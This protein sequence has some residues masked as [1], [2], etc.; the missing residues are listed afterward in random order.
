M[1]LCERLVSS[2]VW[3]VRVVLGLIDLV[4]LLLRVKAVGRR[5]ARRSEQPFSVVAEWKRSVRR[6]GEKPFL[7]VCAS[8]D[9]VIRE[10]SYAATDELAEEFAQWLG[11]ST[12][13][14]RGETVGV[15]MGTSAEFVVILLGL[16]KAGCRAA[17]VN[18]AL[19]GEPL[20]HAL[21]SALGDRKPRLIV[22]DAE[23]A[24]S[25][26]LSG[27]RARVV[28][29]NS[30][31]G[32]KLRLWHKQRRLNKDDDDLLN[33]DLD[34]LDDDD[35]KRN[36]SRWRFSLLR[37]HWRFRVPPAGTLRRVA[38]KD[39]KHYRR[40]DLEEAAAATGSP[41]ESSVDRKDEDIF[42]YIYTSGTTGLPKAARITHARA[43]S[44]G[45]CFRTTCRLRDSDRV[46][47]ALPLYHATAGLMGLFGV[48]GAGASLLLRRK[49]STSA[50][51]EDLL[52]KRAT[53][54]LYVGEMARYLASSNSSS[55]ETTL[56]PPT[57]KAPLRKKNLRFAFGNGMPVD[58]WEAFRLCLGVERVVEFYGS[59]EGNV[60][61]FNNVGV[62]G[63]CGLVPRPFLWL[64]PIFVARV[65]EEDDGSC[66]LL[67]DG[68][69]GLCVQCR[70]NEAGELLG[71][72]NHSNPARAFDGY[73]NSEAT[74]QKIARSVQKTDD[75]FFR[76]GDL[77]TMDTFGFLY[78]VD[79]V[80]DTFRWKGEN[81][82]SL[83]VARACLQ[84]APHI[85]KEAIVYGLRPPNHDSTSSEGK[86]PVLAA[87]LQEN[88]QALHDDHWPR[89]LYEHLHT[90]SGLPPF[91]LPRFLRIVHRL[92]TT[93]SHK[94]QKM[95]LIKRNFDPHGSDRLYV[96]D[97][98]ALSYIPFDDHARR[99][100]ET[101]ALRL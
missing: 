23:F 51:K 82:S 96:R 26:R 86:C 70:P 54:C 92:P 99:R 37:R 56:P 76:S 84:A 5:V 31:D 14:R 95:N 88:N 80:G 8:G 101:A 46:Y 81:S 65:L 68:K 15:I 91:A 21:G 57:K 89:L 97:P 40:E 22:A 38:S 9:N 35:D 3:V 32:P 85:L 83:Q 25:A 1:M 58:I 36:K 13:T 100:L 53:G 48:I 28:V 87:C 63:A 2:C 39:K 72:I 30:D 75:A 18:V 17:L 73:V 60:Q 49:F 55:S 34:D 6:N 74:D 12:A 67:R 61:L 50:F 4:V 11:S 45:I 71:H 16:A 64:Y 78:F 42:A 44:A 66:R 33:D 19:T 62:V 24:E 52:E 10:L 59:T 27:H 93:A 77:V 41:S 29:P 20:S 79:R 69:T 7:E 43:W 94:Y 90:R 98:D 47:C